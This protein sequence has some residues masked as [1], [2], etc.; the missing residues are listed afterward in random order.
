MSV[1]YSAT[2]NEP[3]RAVEIAAQVVDRYR[4]FPQNHL[5][6]SELHDAIMQL[7]E[8]ICSTEDAGYDPAEILRD[9]SQ[10]TVS[11]VNAA[12][13]ACDIHLQRDFAQRVIQGKAAIADFV[14]HDQFARLVSREIALLGNNSFRR[15]LVIGAG[16]FPATPIQVHLQTTLP[17]DCIALGPEDARIAASLL[18]RCGFTTR[19]R[20]AA[21]AAAFDPAGYDVV[22][23]DVLARPKKK[24][25]NTLRKRVRLGCQIL[26]RTTSG[27]RQLLYEE[28][29]DRAL[30]GFHRRKSHRAEKGEL[31]STLL[32]EAAA[33]AAGDVQLRWLSGID[34]KLGSQLLALMNRTLKEETTIGYPGPIDEETGQ[35]IMSE[36]NED[37][38]SGHRHV[39][40]AYKGEATVGQLILTPNSSPN[41]RHIV[42]L[43]RGTIDASFRGGGLALRAFQE[44][45]R[46]CEELGREVI[47]LDVRAGTHAA[48]W[49]QHFGFRPYGL[50]EDYARVGAKRYQGLYLTQTTAELRQRLAELGS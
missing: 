37:V 19:I 22:V 25:L 45:A 12:K 38:K 8:I 3:A 16:P 30:R 49:W 11:S 26:C 14:H 29:P 9:F 13:A 32:L 6:F 18:E 33:S 44:V 4:L 35:A 48:V 50:L 7:E 15:V 24:I 39:L 47:C 20:V 43:T 31:I 36:L 27:L 21:D 2:R 41:H 1:A 28:V 17:V 34:R 10:N 40:V 46:R 42:E 23:V 5:N